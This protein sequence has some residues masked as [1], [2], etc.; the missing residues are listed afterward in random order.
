[1]LLIV[2][3]VIFILPFASPWPDG[4]EKVASLLGFEQKE[5]HQPL[6][7][8]PMSGYQIP[9][10]SS[11]TTATALA[12]LIGALSVF[13]LSVVMARV[14]TPASHEEKVHGPHAS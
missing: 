2:G 14:L 4:L 8:S 7:P 13:G 9:G 10:I 1:M 12:G 6:I 3:T 11:S 5:I